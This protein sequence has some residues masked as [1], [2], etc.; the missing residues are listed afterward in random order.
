MDSK[1]IGLLK[2]DDFA[3]KEIIHGAGFAWSENAPLEKPDKYPKS[4][5]QTSFPRFDG[6]KNCH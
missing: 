5:S 4:S 3:A 2:V 1:I 6:R